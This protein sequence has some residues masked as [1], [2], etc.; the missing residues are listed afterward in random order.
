MNGATKQVARPQVEIYTDGACDP[1]P[2]PGG[3]GVVLSHPQ[4]RTET[5]GG[6]R[7]TTNNRMEIY[8]AIKGFAGSACRASP[9]CL[10]D[11]SLL[12][13]LVYKS[14]IYSIHDMTEY[15]IKT[16][17]QLGAVLRGYRKNQRLTQRDV[18]ARV[19]LAQNAVSQL[20]TE[21][22]RAGLARVFKLL[23]ALNLELVVR[24]RGTPERRSDW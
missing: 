3:Y 14:V 17:E 19:G 15:P 22:G 13:C 21:P 20:E 11:K 9:S 7:L 8:A 10:Y 24:P 6:F 23:A 12:S 4:N 1:N 5:S 18:G 2:G 16:P